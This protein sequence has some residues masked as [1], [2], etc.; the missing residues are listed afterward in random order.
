MGKIGNVSFLLVSVLKKESTLL[1]KKLKKTK[2]KDNHKKE[3]KYLYM[4]VPRDQ[5]WRGRNLL[6]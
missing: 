4:K 6:V 1:K 2:D 3:N 5:K